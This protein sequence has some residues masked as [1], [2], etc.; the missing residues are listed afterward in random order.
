MQSRHLRSPL[1]HLADVRYT[2]VGVRLHAELRTASS[3]GPFQSPQTSC[4]DHRTQQTR[5]KRA[6]MGQRARVPKE[7]LAQANARAIKADEGKDVNDEDEDE[8]DE[9][10]DDQQ[11][12]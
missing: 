8:K 5:T 9:E 11:H 10:H 2:L 3:T 1:V 6:T 4:R 12:Q 7:A